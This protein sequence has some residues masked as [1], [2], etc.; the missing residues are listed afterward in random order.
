MARQE[1]VFHCDGNEEETG[2][3]QQIVTLVAIHNHM[4]GHWIENKRSRSYHTTYLCPR[5]QNEMM[6]LLGDEVRKRIITEVKE[7]GFFGVSADTT[8]D[9][10]HK[11][12][13]ATVCRYIDSCGDAKERLISMK[14]VCTKACDATA[15]EIIK[16]LQNSSLNTEELS[17]QSYDFTNSMSGCFNGAQKKLQ[18]QL[19]KTV[20]DVPCQGYRSNTVIE[21]SVNASSIVSNM[22]TIM[23]EVYV[24]F[25][26]STKRF[27]L[28][29]SFQVSLNSCKSA[30]TT[31]NPIENKAC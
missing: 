27:A 1:I 11:D 14:S 2:N 23:E 19:Q 15:K 8:P 20:P 21:H 17:F 7:A 26:S 6:Q 10:S 24:F 3:F 5:S 18:E 29:L 22:F 28:L 12:Q 13:M 25:T 16:V 30:S 9:L 31:N 4:L